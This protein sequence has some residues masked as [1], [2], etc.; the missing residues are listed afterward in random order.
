MEFLA[1]EVEEEALRAGRRFVGQIGPHNLALLQ[2]RKIIGG[3]PVARGIFLAEIDDAGFQ[4]FQSRVTVA[5]ILEADLIEIIAAL[6]D[7]QI[8]RPVIGA[9]LIGH[10]FAGLEGFYFVGAGAQGWLERR[11]REVHLR[12]IGFG[13]DRQFGDGQRQV[14]GALALEAVAHL[15]LAQ[16]LAGFDIADGDLDAL[17]AFSRQQPETV[18]DILGGERRAI[19]ECRFRAQ[20]EG[21]A[22]PVG[23][24]IGGLGG[25]AIHRVGLVVGPRH[26]AVE[27]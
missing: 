2:G 13:K 5:E 3:G 25:E 14:A 9:A 17:V 7:G 1:P 23:G 22:L 26:Q 18:A 15:S 21:D 12:V 24:K 19:G 20:G 11:F 6:V 10:I 4:S 8:L 27:H 16:H